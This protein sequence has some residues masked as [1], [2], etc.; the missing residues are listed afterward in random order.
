MEF[1]AKRAG[2]VKTVVVD[3]ASHA[4]MISHPEEVAALIEEA[5][6]VH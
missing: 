2:T 3:G 5:A 4:V 1:M 6:S